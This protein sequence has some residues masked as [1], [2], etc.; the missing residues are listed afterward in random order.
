MFWAKSG[1]AVSKNDVNVDFGH[2]LSIKQPK[3][4]QAVFPDT[5]FPQAQV[6]TGEPLGFARRSWLE[7]LAGVYAN[8]DARTLT[9]A[10]ATDTLTF[11][12]PH[13]EQNT[14]KRFLGEIKI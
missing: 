13:P 10:F 9:S 7:P 4:Y 3:V 2:R 11:T 6:K 5:Q 12:Q 1:Q 14:R 8:G